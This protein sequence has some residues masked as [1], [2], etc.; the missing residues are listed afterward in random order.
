MGWKGQNFLVLMPK[1]SY[2]SHF[3]AKPESQDF[4]FSDDMCTKSYFYQLE[5]TIH[6]SFTYKSWQEKAIL[7]GAVHKSVCTQ[8]VYCL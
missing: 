7:P 3:P 5:H 4:K 8:S 1:I 2:Y 6:S